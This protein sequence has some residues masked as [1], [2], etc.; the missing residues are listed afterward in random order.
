M[1]TIKIKGGSR[2]GYN[3]LSKWESK[4][5]NGIK[6]KVKINVIDLT[7][8]H[9]LTNLNELFINDKKFSIFSNHNHIYDLFCIR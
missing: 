1:N 7:A 8:L 4:M 9:G 2:S 3:A 5:D 6:Y